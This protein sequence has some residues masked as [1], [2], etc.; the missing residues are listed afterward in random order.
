MIK[1]HIIE[2]LNSRCEYRDVTQTGYYFHK[3]TENDIDF[4]NNNTRNHCVEIRD[5]HQ[6]D[7]YL[8]ESC[9]TVLEKYEDYDFSK[10]M[11]IEILQTMLEKVMARLDKVEN[12]ILEI[13][14]LQKNT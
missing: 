11:K 6:P 8:C 7:L 2:E 1:S 12:E 13:K 9:R 5:G 10:D 14:L 4:E 3:W